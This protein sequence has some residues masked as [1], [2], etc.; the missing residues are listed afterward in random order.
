MRHLKL[1]EP[2]ACGFDACAN[3][4]PEPLGK[5]ASSAPAIVEQIQARCPFFS[6]PGKKQTDMIPSRTDPLL[7][8]SVARFIADVNTNYDSIS[9]LI[10]NGHRHRQD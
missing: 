5:N 9:V 8:W 10:A 2:V 7:R 3:A 1:I 4:R 6:P